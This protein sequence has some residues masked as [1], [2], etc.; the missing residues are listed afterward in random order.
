MPALPPTP[1]VEPV[2]AAPP[3]QQA[4]PKVGRL[5]LER[6]EA[7]RTWLEQLPDDRWFI[8][9]FATDANRHAEVETLLRRLASS[10][11]DMDRIHVY[12]S[13]LSGKPRFGVTYGDYATSAAAAAAMR[14]LP[15]PLQSSQPYPRQVVRLR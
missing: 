2:L 14:G 5:T 13:D 8:Q 6:L 9:I 10:K 11:V 7:G 4:E 3:P 12:H 1:K 15:E